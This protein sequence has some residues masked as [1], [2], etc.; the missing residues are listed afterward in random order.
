M[1]LERV[2]LI[3]VAEP[4]GLV[5]AHQFVVES[6]SSSG[7]VFV[8]RLGSTE[9]RAVVRHEL[10]STRGLFR[11]LSASI[12]DLRAPFFSRFE[13]RKLSYDSGFY[14]LTASD[15]ARFA[16]VML[17]SMERVDLLAS[18]VPGEAMFLEKLGHARIIELESL[19]PFWAHKPWTS[20]L[21][22]RRVLVIH[23]FADTIRAQFEGARNGLFPETGIL[24][25][26]QLQTLRS[27]Q[28]LGGPDSRFNTWFDA[29]DW[30]TEECLKREFDVALI[31]A[32]AYGFPLAARLKAEGRKAIHL[33]GVLQVLFGIRGRRWDSIPKYRAL[34]NSHWTSPFPHEVPNRAYRLGQGSYW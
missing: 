34:Y 27:V 21:D 6:L 14:P 16:E 26:F 8:G 11:R 7:S 28:S 3:D 20:A 25:D 1:G 22:G 13:N 12:T 18:W 33:G 5:D 23:P 4:L 9:L 10:R 32:G 17:W 15:V 19:E 2:R 24:P 30:M 31:G 29:L